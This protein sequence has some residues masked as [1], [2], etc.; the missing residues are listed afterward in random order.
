M[1]Q[2]EPCLSD[3]EGT[4]RRDSLS[5]IHA[6]GQQLQIGIVSRIG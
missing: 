6:S 5:W 2:H 4:M 3:A 1:R